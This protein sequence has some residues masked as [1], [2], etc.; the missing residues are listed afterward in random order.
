MRIGTMLLLCMVVLLTSCA[1]QTPPEEKRVTPVSPS[2]EGTEEVLN[3]F[4]SMA[5]AGSEPH[6]LKAYI[7]AHIETLTPLEAEVL[8]DG[9]ID[10]V[11]RYEEPYGD[12]FKDLGY[13]ERVLGNDALDDRGRIQY[14]ALGPGFAE[15]FLHKTIDTFYQLQW[16]DEELVLVTDFRVFKVYTPYVTPYMQSY[17]EIMAQERAKP[18]A[19]EDLLAIDREALWKRIREVEV[20]LETYR[21]TRRFE[22]VQQLYADYARLFLLGAKSPDEVVDDISDEQR[23]FYRRLSQQQLDSPLASMLEGYLVV[24]GSSDGQMTDEVKAYAEELIDQIL[25]GE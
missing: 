4:R 1:P 14:D 6:E 20:F 25:R 15:G 3:T 24:I 21:G 11:H 19:V 18:S 10:V 8:V 22:E 2:T 17:I 9:L 16:D 23:G 5:E 7:D 12:A 13:D